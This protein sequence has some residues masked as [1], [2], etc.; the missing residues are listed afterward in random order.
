M[1]P[2]LE[3]AAR[4]Q[5]AP[6]Q[7]ARRIEARIIALFTA[8]TCTFL[9]VYSTQ[10][11]LPTFRSVFRSSE[12]YVS[13]TVSATTIAVAIAAPAI[14]LIAER[15][16]RKRLMISALLALSVPTFLAATANSLQ[17]L[18][19]WRFAQGL[20]VP[21]IAAV[22]MAYIGEEW[23][24]TGV[25]Y[26][27]GAY[28]SGTMMGGFLGRFVTGLV[29]EHAN[30]RWSF[31]ALGVLTW[32]GAVIVWRW[33]PRSRNFVP[34][35]NARATLKSGLAHLRNP[36]AVACF[37]T[38]FLL[39]FSMIG[40]T[41]YTN[42]YLAAPPFRLNPAQL[43]SV[44]S[45]YLLGMIVSPMAGRFM[46][47][48]GY[49]RTI[50]VAIMTSLAGL[51]LTLKLWLPSVIAGLSM[52]TAGTFATQAATTAHLGVVTGKARSSAAGIYLTFYYTGGALGALVPSLFWARAGWPATAAL[53]SCTCLMTLALG[54]VASRKSG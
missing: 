54:C 51:C 28:V 22:I 32:T 53:L 14:G 40:T 20:A 34:S 2:V 13:L 15:I 38:G 31:A 39:L 18:I 29:T 35:A 27:M 48:N 6:P 7:T 17:S 46:D 44:F 45:M 25:G 47:R 1:S 26:P 5:A 43:G 10:A 9:N 42:F 24:R 37:G 33:L 50:V 36:R 8:G 30:W 12:G 16:E 49:R 4:T 41:T 19:L 3:M 23:P 11:L 21:G 52:M